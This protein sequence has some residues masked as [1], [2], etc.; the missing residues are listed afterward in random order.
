ME[1][2]PGILLKSKKLYHLRNEHVPLS[3]GHLSPWPERLDDVPAPGSVVPGQPCV[4]QTPQAQQ[5]AQ[6]NII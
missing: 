4:A 6:V 1:K 3:P 5:A 2:L